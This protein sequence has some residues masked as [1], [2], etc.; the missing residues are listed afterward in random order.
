MPFEFTAENKKRFEEI[1]AR[2]PKRMAAM[3]P[4]LWLAQH[5]H[6]WIST[7]V[8]EYVAALLQVPP[9]KVYEVVTFYTMFHQEPVGKHHFQVCRTLSCQLR[10]AETI[11]AHLEKRLGIKVGET[12]S[13]GKFTLS[14]V[15]CLGSCGTAPMLQLNNDYHENL[16]PENL[17]V[18]LEGLKK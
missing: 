16:N 2:Y 8:M 7:E 15:E 18:L 10:G 11:T 14:E 1:V 9:S 6:G 13:D 17:D 12:S 3:L 4:T 5:Q